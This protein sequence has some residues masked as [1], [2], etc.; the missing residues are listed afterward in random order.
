MLPPL[1]TCTLHVAVASALKDGVQGNLKEHPGLK[2]LLEGVNRNLCNATKKKLAIEGRHLRGPLTRPALDAD[3]D[4]DAWT[5]EWASSGS[6][7]RLS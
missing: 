7:R 6:Q 1:L 5:G 3:A 4:A 2:K